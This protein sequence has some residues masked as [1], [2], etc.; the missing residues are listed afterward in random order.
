MP[1]FA[2]NEAYEKALLMREHRRALVPRRAG[3]NDT[4][5]IPQ[6]RRVVK[7]RSTEFAHIAG[8]T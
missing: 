2:K 5:S 3:T 6:I 1:G 4:I 8:H 7:C